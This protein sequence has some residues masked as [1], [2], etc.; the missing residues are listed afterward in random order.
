MHEPGAPGTTLVYTG[1]SGWTRAA[2]CEA[3]MRGDPLVLPLVV[4]ET[5]IGY[6]VFDV[7]GGSL[8]IRLYAQDGETVLD[9]VE[10]K[11]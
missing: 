10:L 11:K 9:S 8:T 2:T 7:D 5:R 4:Y 3:A 6:T 1:N